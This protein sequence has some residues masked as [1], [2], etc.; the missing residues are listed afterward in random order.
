MKRTPKK[1]VYYRKN[2]RLDDEDME[3]ANVT[4]AVRSQTEDLREALI[5]E[6]VFEDNP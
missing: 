1:S 3:Q 6:H 2:L 5:G 4:L